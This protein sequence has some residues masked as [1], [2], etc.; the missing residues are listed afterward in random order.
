MWVFG[1]VEDELDKR[2]IPPPH[3]TVSVEHAASVSPAVIAYLRR[4]MIEG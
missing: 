3:E 4:I 1:I 2:V